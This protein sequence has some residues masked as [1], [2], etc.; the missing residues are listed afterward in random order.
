MDLLAIGEQ[1][2]DIIQRMGTLGV[3]GELNPPPGWVGSGGRLDRS[4]GFNLEI[5]FSPS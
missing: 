3:A 5:H 4:F 1:A 2:V